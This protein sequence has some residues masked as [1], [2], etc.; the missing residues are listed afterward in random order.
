MM[1]PSPKCYILSFSEIDTMDT[2]EKIVDV[3]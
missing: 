3:L 1:D 2:A